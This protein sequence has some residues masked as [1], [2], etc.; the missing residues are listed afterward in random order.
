MKPHCLIPWTNIDIGPRGHIVPCCKFEDDNEQFNITTHSIDEYTRSDFLNEIKDNMLQGTW[1]EGCIRCKTEELNGIQSK[2]QLDSQRWQQEFE[3]YTPDQ[4]YITASIGFGNTC[5]LK[6]I[7]CNPT[8]S[9]RWRKEY[10]DLHGI[11]KPPVETIN[12]GVNDIY[13]SMPNLIHF[14]VIGGEPLIS[15]PEKQQELLLR[16]VLSGQSRNMTLHYTTNAQ[17]FPGEVWWDL[18]RNFKEIDMQLSIDGVGSR[19]E[20]IRHPASSEVLE[21]NVK[22]WKQTCAEQN[23]L[24]LSISH[25]LS[26]Y[27]IYY[28]DEFFAW[29]DLY[30]L[31]RPWIGR[32]NTPRYMRV[33]VFPHPIKQN[34][35]EHLR[36]SKYED[37]HTWANFLAAND[38]S[39]HWQE[40]LQRRDWHDIYRNTDFATTFP[41]LARIID[42][43]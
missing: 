3:N 6:C 36:T 20:Y 34:I 2:R 19:Y 25:T 31:P 15:E 35:I 11:D 9:S 8:S 4:G 22:L 29:C 1:P 33:E 38:S 26:A 40:F 10:L 39:E 30:Q 14:D 41:E 37:V 32:V 13:S 7:T 43:I 17:Q 28:L 18:W 16:Y 21:Q 12:A 42:G 23:N 5:N 27:N 24:K